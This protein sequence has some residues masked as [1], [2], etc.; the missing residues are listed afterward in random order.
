MKKP[1]KFYEAFAAAFFTQFLLLSGPSWV[2]A[3][4]A[5]ILSIDEVPPE[6]STQVWSPLFQA[7]WEKLNEMQRGELE[8]VVPPN[9]LVTKLEGFR[10]QAQEV[11]PKDG[12]AVYAGPATHEFARE[13]AASVKKR[14]GIEL[15]S[16][17]VPAIPQGKTA[18]GFL[19]RDLEFEKKFFRSRARAL[20]FRA[21]TGET[22]LVEFFGTA[23]DRS[24]GFGDF[25]KVLRYDPEGSSFVLSITTERE[26]ENLLVYRPDREYSLRVAMEHVKNAMEDPQAGPYGSLKHGSL[27][28]KDV[29]K[30][31][32]VAVDADTDF[33]DQL[34]GSLHYAGEPLPWQVAG[35][36]QVVRFELFEEGARVRAEAGVSARPFGDLPK[37]PPVIPRSFVCDRPFYVFLWRE[38]GDWPYLATWIGGVECLTP[39]RK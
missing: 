24:G 12:Y 15:D 20:E 28:R 33:T 19:L 27:H 31:P 11:M 10:W 13:M 8:K 34:R 17:R 29:V 2:A 30:I 26:G 25:V 16:S 6:G 22:H 37:P 36:F 9:D 21:R 3:G 5:C 32:Y 38:G 39:F 4:P 18:Y 7:S 23:G 14:F 35:A 1:L